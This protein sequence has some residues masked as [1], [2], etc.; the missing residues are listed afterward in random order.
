MQLPRE[1]LELAGVVEGSGVGVTEGEAPAFAGL[2]ERLAS[3][4]GVGVI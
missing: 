3:G 4:S 1:C 2:G